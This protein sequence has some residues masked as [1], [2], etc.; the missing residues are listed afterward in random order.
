MKIAMIGHKRIP[1]RV[2]GVEIVVD[3]LSRRMAA[4][5]HRVEVYNRNTGQKG[6]KTYRGVRLIEVPTSR[7]QSLNALI[8]SLLAT[9]RALFGRY[10][11]V[12]YHAEGPCAML[13]LA[14]FF[15]IRT[16]ATI[17][18]LDWQRSKWGGFATRYLRFGEKMAAKYADELIVLSE[19]MQTY[20]RDTYGREA[21]LIPN[22]I[23]RIVRQEAEIITE[24]YG[25]TN[26][27]Y[28]LFLARLT[29]E[30][31]LDVL[32]DAYA[33]LETDKPLVVAG[34]LTPE[35][36]YIREIQQKAAADPRVRLVGFVEGR[37]LAELLTNC[38][39]YI[40][41]S[42]LEGMPISL[43]EA[44]SLGARCVVSDIPENTEVAKGY[45]HTFEK[46]SA[47]ALQ[48]VVQ[49]LLEREALH[50]RN[51]D[52]AKTPEE[53]EGQIREIV[54][55]YDWDEVT[56]RTLRLYAERARG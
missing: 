50:D 51:F 2:G 26:G 5:G 12:H 23:D 40:L 6:P 21:H 17:H 3:E 48:R 43:L 24:K 28:L 32:L 9:L 44:I 16:V 29:P 46:G 13:F 47:K 31:G 8:Y 34:G 30:K 27:G 14:H 11:V 25:L 49:Q 1:S 42:Y 36:E 15:R 54:S 39:V 38:Y 4:A 52:A 19:A 33:G 45:L 18:G 7:R 53:V 35:T 56:D 37:E 20:F 10:D 41:P 22:G 55:R